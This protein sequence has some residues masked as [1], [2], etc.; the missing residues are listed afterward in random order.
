VVVLG[1]LVLFIINR[2]NSSSTLGLSQV[3]AASASTSTSDPLDQLSSADI[4]LS[5]ARATNLPESVAVQDQSESV[6]A[7]L[8]IVPTDNDIAPKPQIVS[9][10]FKSNQDIQ[11]YTTQPGDTIASV[12]AKFNITSSSVEWSNNNVTN[13]TA[14]LHLLIPPISGIVY[15]VKA[16][17]TPASLAQ[18]YSSN[19]TQ[20]VAYNDAEI[21]GL[22]PGERI[23]IPNA[24]QPATP[25]YNY[26]S[27]VYATSSN[28]GG[29]GN[30]SNNGYDF[31]YCTWYVA[32]QISVPTNWG[33]AST[34]SY[35]A[36]LSG[37]NVSST[38]S[39][40]SIAQTPFA[41]GGEGHVAIVT[42]VSADGSQ[43][44]FKDMNGIAGWDRVGYSGWVS[45]STY[46]HYISH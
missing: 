46:P 27:A 12:A 7:D 36:G 29:G 28:V 4:A 26:F 44:Q 40:G 35:Y 1:V 42:A 6:N 43:I 21:S 13:L 11:T 31:G 17:D 16:G 41:A 5:V 3:S 39:V 14:G 33:N 18:K 10:A 32:T 9:T 8:A 20:L 30:S 34:W 38:P 25:S 24:Q 2:S 19:Q 22:Y 37:W 23:I 15:T 45:S